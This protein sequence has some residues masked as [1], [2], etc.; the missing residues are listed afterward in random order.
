MIFTF[1]SASILPKQESKKQD[2]EQLARWNAEWEAYNKQLLYGA[3]VMNV[4]NK[5]EEYTGTDYAVSITV[6]DQDDEEIGKSGI[7][8]NDLYEC[9]ELKYSDVTGRVNSITFKVKN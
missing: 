6:L 7:D 4:I 5:S 1:G 8:M 3:D 2:V 9:K